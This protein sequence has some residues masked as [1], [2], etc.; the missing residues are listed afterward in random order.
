MARL[1][2]HFQWYDMRLNINTQP[3]VT[4]DNPFAD[5]FIPATYHLAW[6]SSLLIENR[7][8]LIQASQSI[9]AQLFTVILNWLNCHPKTFSL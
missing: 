8:L 2:I 7:V 9:L 6:W 4:A 1:S 3:Q 5:S